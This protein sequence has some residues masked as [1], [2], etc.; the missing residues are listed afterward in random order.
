MD[1]FVTKSDGSQY[2][3]ERESMWPGQQFGLQV[4]RFY[5]GSLIAG[6]SAQ[7]LNVCW[8]VGEEYHYAPKKRVPGYSCV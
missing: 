8:L 2:F 4:A 7:Y 3:Y 1:Q 5:E 6:H